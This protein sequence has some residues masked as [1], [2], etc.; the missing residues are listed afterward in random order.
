[1]GCTADSI[2]QTPNRGEGEATKPG[3]KAIQSAPDQTTAQKESHTTTLKESHTP[4]TGGC[5]LQ[6]PT[7]THKPKVLILTQTES[8]IPHLTKLTQTESLYL[9]Y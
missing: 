8:H 6:Q 2:T 5:D 7:P 4:P 9:G 3:K 1:M